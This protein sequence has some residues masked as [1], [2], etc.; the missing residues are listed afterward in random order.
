MQMRET[1]LQGHFQCFS[2]VAFAGV[3][4]DFSASQKSSVTCVN[5]VSC[6]LADLIHF[7][8]NTT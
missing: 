7:H 3:F 4:L 5:S 8:N 2:E 6:Q 1:T